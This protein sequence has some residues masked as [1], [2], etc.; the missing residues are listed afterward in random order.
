MTFSMRTPL[1][2]L[3]VEEPPD[4]DTP[5]EDPPDRDPPVEEPPPEMG[6]GPSRITP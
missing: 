3:P 2:H 1:D 6:I 4:N 5:P